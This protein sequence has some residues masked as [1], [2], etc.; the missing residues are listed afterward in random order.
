MAGSQLLK[1]NNE[2][3]HCLNISE[4][5]AKVDPRHPIP[6]PIA[7]PLMYEQGPH[8]TGRLSGSQLPRCLFGILCRISPSFPEV[9]SLFSHIQVTLTVS[10]SRL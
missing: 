1:E 5:G 9:G 2:S 10:H 4:T 6:N 8:G 3:Q 7:S